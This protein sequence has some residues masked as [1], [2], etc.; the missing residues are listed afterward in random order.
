MA[1]QFDPALFEEYDESLFEPSA[2]A[3]ESRPVQALAQGIGQGATL[4]YMN[5]INSALEPGFAKLGDF[6]SGK[7]VS[8]NLPEYDSRLAEYQAR[9][10]ELKE[11]NPIAS[12]A[13]QLIGAI[14][15]S[16]AVGAG[17][18]ALGFGG[19]A[20][21]TGLKGYLGNIGKGAVTGAVTGAAYNPG[22][23]SRF[24]NAVAGGIVGGA[25]PAIAGAVKPV[26]SRMGQYF[27][28]MK[29]PEAKAYVENTAQVKDLAN[30]LAQGQES[31]VQDIGKNILT[32]ATQEVG[33]NADP[34][35]IKRLTK[36]AEGNADAYFKN[37]SVD[38]LAEIQNLEKLGASG[39]EKYARM[40]GAAETLNPRGGNALS[41]SGI[42]FRPM[43]RAMLRGAPLL[44]KAAAPLTQKTLAQIIAEGNR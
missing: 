43:G 23:G 21:A 29:A 4:G 33:G 35:L 18:K 20:A 37:S 10:A 19:K 41:V 44:D 36:A 12:G 11:A 39:V 28:G 13:G 24:D 34:G 40:R 14:G 3:P 32:K 16:G 5:E 30:K 27:S 2:P 25:V 26:M 42:A 31:Q 15:S 9:E 6:I 22:E 17:A 8:E 38:R 1:Q 7:D